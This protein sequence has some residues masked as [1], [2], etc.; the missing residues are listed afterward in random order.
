MLQIYKIIYVTQRNPPVS[1]LTQYKSPSC[2][3]WNVIGLLSERKTTED[4]NTNCDSAAAPR[5]VLS[6]RGTVTLQHLDVLYL[7]M[8]RV[9]G[10]EEELMFTVLVSGRR[11]DN[12]TQVWFSAVPAFPVTFQNKAEQSFIFLYF[13]LKII[14]RNV[15]MNKQ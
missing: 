6:T 7:Y 4:K 9:T 14:I 13:T 10:T 5:F 15:N 11:H 2:P 3:Q 8:C 1:D 12:N